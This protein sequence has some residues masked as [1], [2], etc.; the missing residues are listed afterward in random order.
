[1]HSVSVYLRW[2]RVP[3]YL[4]ASLRPFA[5]RNFGTRMEGTLIDSPVRG[6]RPVL[7]GRILVE[8]MPRP[9]IETSSPFLRAAI[10]VSIKVSTT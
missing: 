6:L 9:A 10:I 3:D 1:M 8:K 4:T 7:A 5:A 2:Y